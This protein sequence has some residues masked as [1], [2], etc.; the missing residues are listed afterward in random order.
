MDGKE[1]IHI[2]IKISH[3][4]CI[5]EYPRDFVSCIDNVKTMSRR[6]RKYTESLDEINIIKIKALLRFNRLFS[7]KKKLVVFGKKYS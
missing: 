7:E 5:D 4:Y 6:S 1:Y 2:Y 3:V